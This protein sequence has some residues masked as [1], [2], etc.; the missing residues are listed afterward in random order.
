MLTPIPKS[1]MPSS[2]AVRVPV[3]GDY[4]GEYGEP[5]TIT[6]VRFESAASLVR[7]DHVLSDGAKGLLFIDAV[8]SLGA[9]E[10][11]VGSLLSIDGQEYAAA[12]K[13]DRYECFNG[14]VHHW[15]IE[16]V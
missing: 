11:P 1:V 7:S 4:G 8:N 2:V 15:E 12:G 10:V 3:E 16:V 14:T 9:F 13:V 6:G 5:Q